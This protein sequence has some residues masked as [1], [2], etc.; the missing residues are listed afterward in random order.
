MALR[1][2][3]L[4]DPFDARWPELRA[5]AL[6]A[7]EDGFDGVWTWDHLAGSVHRQDRVLECWT[8]L[9]ALAGVLSRVSLGP[10]VLNV[11]NR[12]PGLVATM[13]ATL[14]EV[15]GGRLLLGLGAGGG[16]DTPYAAEQWALGRE[17]PSDATR[18]EQV[19]EAVDVIRR[20]WTGRTDPFEGR[21]YRLG[22]AGGFV[23]PEPAPPIVIGAF[24]PKMAELAG[25]VGD[26]INTQAAH[27]RLGELIDRARDARS[28]AGRDPSG[29]VVTVFAGLE[30]RWLEASSPDRGRLRD[31]GVDRLILLVHPPF[32]VEGIRAAGRRLNGG[33]G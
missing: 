25:R 2:D 7:E 24:G 4:F 23:R 18:R 3:L 10:L 6:A 29:F 20:L 8:V 32:D 28:T 1:T 11:A 14:Q 13:A 9:S 27:P 17:V 19:A 16:A 31:L 22:R 30:R 26:G 5:A 15:S 12:H 21:H 33:A